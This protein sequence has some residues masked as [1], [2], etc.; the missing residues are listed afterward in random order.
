MK[1]IY[2]ALGIL[3]SQG[4]SLRR[5]FAS[6]SLGVV[7]V[8]ISSIL[9]ASIFITG[10][11]WLIS[12]MSVRDIREFLFVVVAVGLSAILCISLW[13]RILLVGQQ[14]MAIDAIQKLQVDPRPPVVYLRPFSEDTRVASNIPLGKQ[15]GIYA[16]S[17]FQLWRRHASKEQL[18]SKR[19]KHLGPFI[20]IGRPG[21]RLCPLGA[22]RLYVSDDEWQEKVKLLIR[23]AEALII[24]P[25]DSEG[26]LWELNTISRSIEPQRVLIIVPNPSIRPLGYAKVRRIIASTL[27]INIPEDSKTV[28]AYFVNGDGIPVALPSMKDLTKF[29]EQVSTL[30]RSVITT[31]QVT[32]H[33]AVDY[34]P[35]V[36]KKK[37]S[38]SLVLATE[39]S[40]S[41]DQ[42]TKNRIGFVRQLQWRSN[43][44]YCLPAMLSVILGFGLTAFFGAVTMSNFE[45]G[46]LTKAIGTGIVF[47]ISLGWFIYS[48]VKAVSLLFLKTHPVGKALQ[49]FG[50][51]G[52]VV[53]DIDSDFCP[54]F[55]SGPL[56]IGRRWLCYVR[57]RTIMIEPTKG[58][59]WAYSENLSIRNGTLHQLVFW[60]RQGIGYALPM[61]PRERETSLKEVRERLPWLHFGYN[62]VL[63]ESWNADRSDFIAYVDERRSKLA[64]KQAS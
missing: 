32:P 16:S 28:E 56:Y 38:N 15:I 20:A 4:K 45:F 49:S 39:G 53:K 58:L 59:I 22:A 2:Q 36:V 35:P 42:S 21:D 19:L 17:G 40:S 62:E 9:P 5:P 50:E 7:A 29:V 1:E 18:I 63:K 12:A 55:T 24:V 11:A 10:S 41:P 60:T 31:A 8:I 48:I 6:K 37:L 34:T 61:S 30:E 27:N 26:T 25:D 33:T 54:S 51:L 23:H 43:I 64:E 47:L 46:D 52:A 13:W 57:K 44:W 3:D 14:M